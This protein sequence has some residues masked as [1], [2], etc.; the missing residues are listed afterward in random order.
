MITCLKRHSHRYNHITPILRLS[1]Y[2]VCVKDEKNCMLPP[3]FKI[4]QFL[5]EKVQVCLEVM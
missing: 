4:H 2:T 3:V 1:I 5:L